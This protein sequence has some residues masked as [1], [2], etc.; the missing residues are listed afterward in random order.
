MGQKRTTFSNHL[1]ALHKE[2]VIIL[3]FQA[4]YDRFFLFKDLDKI[5]RI[6]FVDRS[7]MLKAIEN[8]TLF[9][10]C[11][12]NDPDDG[13]HS[14]KNLL[15]EMP[16]EHSNRAKVIKYIDAFEKGIQEL[17][18]KRRNTP[19]AHLKIGDEDMEITPTWNLKP[20]IKALIDILDLANE[21]EL[22]Y[23]W[24]DGSQEKYNLR[25]TFLNNHNK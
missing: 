20:A 9:R 2:L 19:L 14:L 24:Q 8:D 4:A 18:R 25:D 21:V 3:R 23:Q 10:I 15:K 17:T 6:E 12:F 22:N 16:V 13:L 1:T 7:I 5:S 11:K